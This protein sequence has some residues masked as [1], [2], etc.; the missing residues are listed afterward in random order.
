MLYIPLESVHNNGDSTSFVY[1]KSGFGLK[2]K[3]IK[4]GKTNDN[5]AEVLSGLEEGEMV[6][7]SSAPE[8]TKKTDE[9]TSEKKSASIQ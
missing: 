4:I 2:K 5:F 7:L 3:E 8:D 9:K 1:V 6:L